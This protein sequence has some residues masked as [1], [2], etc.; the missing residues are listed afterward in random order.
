MAINRKI[1][2][3]Y[4]ARNRRKKIKALLTAALAIPGIGISTTA[5]AQSAPEPAEIRFLYGGYSDY[6]GSGTDRVS[7]N[8]PMLWLKT[9]LGA[10]TTLE[11][12]GVLD[13]VSG[14]SP[15]YLDSLSGA[16]G[17]GIHEY[18]KAIDGKLTHSWER[19]SLGVGAAFSTEHDYESKSGS[20]EGKWWTED[21]NTTLAAG[22]SADSDD[23]SSS[24]DS[25]FNDTRHT[26]HYFFGVTQVISPNDIIQSNISYDDANGYLSDPYKPL[27]NR[28]R[29]RESWA[30]LTRYNRYLDSLDAS[31]HL[32]YRLY[33]DSYG[34]LS[35]TVEIALYK[36]FGDGWM[37]RPSIRYYTQKSADFF[38][39]TFPPETVGG[40]FSA[41]ERMGTFGGVTVGVK[42]EKDLGRGFSAS[43][44]VDYLVQD[45]GLALS[46]GTKAN[47]EK[48]YAPFF[49]IGIAKK[50]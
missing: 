1:H 44:G 20:L 45:P 23:I 37:V 35:H 31:L 5:L 48:F 46:G 49:T 2:P 3:R 12:S 15:W 19:F 42:L 50:F 28:P 6:Q 10:D 11:M 16:S 30:W 29:S 9:P 47:V 14:A 17:L 40:Y 36:P 39:A 33:H 22:F 34:I 7:V 21:K 41:D 27:D 32:D 25:T 4:R 18:R 13:S 38:S 26:Q 24:I 8:S 43:A